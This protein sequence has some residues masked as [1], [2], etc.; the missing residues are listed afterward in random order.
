MTALALD[1]IDR[2]LLNQLQTNARL[3]FVALGVLM[4][5]SESSVRRRVERLR[6]I[7]V[8][9]KEVAILS[10]QMAGGIRVIVTVTFERESPELYARFRQ[11]IK[12]LAMVE[13]CYSVA[14]VLDFILIVRA[15][16]LPSYEAWG[17]RELMSWPEIRRYDSHVIWSTV[18]Y[19]TQIV[20]PED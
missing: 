14:G 3:S 13:Q 9:D 19:S 15:D 6:T 8:I 18:K 2:R 17:E 10:E 5:L 1:A 12:S 16:D 4:D 11:H 7:G 20:L